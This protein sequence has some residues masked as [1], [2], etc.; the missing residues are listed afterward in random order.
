MKKKLKNSHSIDLTL[1]ELFEP[2]YGDNLMVKNNFSGLVSSL[3][4][5]GNTDFDAL[6]EFMFEIARDYSGFSN[7]SSQYV[8]G[9]M[10]SYIYNS[11][12]KRISY[13]IHNILT[14]FDIVDNLDN[15][16]NTEWFNSLCVT[17]WREINF[18]YLK[19]WQ[20]LYTTLN[21]EYEILS[22]L[23]IKDSRE[24][25]DNLISSDTSKTEDN[26]T[27]NTKSS[28][29]GY[30]TSNEPKPSDKSESSDNRVNER[31]DKYSRDTTITHTYNK[32][33]NLG[34]MSNTDLVRKEFEFR[35][36]AFLK[37][38]MYNDMD[39]VFTRKYY[40]GEF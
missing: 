25:N 4:G 1:G 9:L 37:N 3:S 6:R 20:S 19:K 33:G 40:G 38:I 34:T 5:A 16:F 10:Q 2:F 36:I 22:P 30:N 29:W 31:T 39:S 23:L 21:K 26:T 32:S 15:L 8:Q 17:L 27:N 35:R 7:L 28:T 18:K 13:Q 24:I 12:S 14:K 11:Y